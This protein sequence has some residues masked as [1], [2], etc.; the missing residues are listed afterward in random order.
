[1]GPRLATLFALVVVSSS[2]PAASRTA[3][4]HDRIGAG[5]RLLPLPPWHR[6]VE[7]L[8]DRK[9][10]PAAFRRADYTPPRGGL[11]MAARLRAGLG[12]PGF[13]YYSL[14]S[15]GFRYS[16][17]SR[18]FVASAIKLAATVG[19]L[20]SLHRRGLTSAAEV[21]LRDVDGLYRG[22]VKH[23]VYDAL[24]NSSNLGYD[25]LTALAGF[26]ALNDGFL[27]ARHGLPRAVIQVRF[28][29]R[30]PAISLRR[31]PGFFFR[32]GSHRG[33]VPE[34]LGKGRHPQC[35]TLQTC[36]SL[37]ELQEVLRRVMLD[38]ELPPRERFA[39]APT[40]LA[41]IRHILLIAR[42]RLQPG[43]SQALGA[44]VHIY[45]NVGRQ[46]GRDLVENAFIETLDRKERYLLA[47]LVPFELRRD[48]K[49]M[50]RKRLIALAR[51]TLR[52]LRRRPRGRVL[53][54]GARAGGPLAVD[55]AR[56]GD[57]LMIGVRVDA[58]A[59][60]VAVSLGSRR[61]PCARQSARHF[62]CAPQRLPTEPTL[63]LLEA[64]AGRRPLA[65]RLLRL[66]VR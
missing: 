8:A 64:R 62:V 41:Y 35:P 54:H 18:F 27:V 12:Q 40:D 58:R 11:V 13:E 49:H 63:L 53:Q 57:A 59:E 28:G 6:R 22:T 56:H 14:G 51:Q 29:G 34:R 25:R 60:Q 5:L 31:S 39:L 30:R 55:L 42:N 7:I 66:G 61:V 21:E 38:R 24:F 44:K 16:Y 32:E 65:Y 50:I 47:V 46:P 15:T 45:N 19:T 23:L 3:P 9:T 10:L 4:Q 20:W 36:V 2:T 48:P 26:D 33:R 52:V 1:M 37:Y 43:V 17:P